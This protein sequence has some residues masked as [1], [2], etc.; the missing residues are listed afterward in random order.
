VTD[1][2]KI[3]HNDAEWSLSA[4][5]FKNNFLKSKMVDNWCSLETHLVSSSDMAIIIF[6]RWQ[7]STILD[8]EN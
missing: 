7:P 8:F 2:Q 4:L 3:W 6:S 1:L 5:T